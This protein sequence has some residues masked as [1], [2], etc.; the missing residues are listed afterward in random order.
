MLYSQSYDNTFD[1]AY[2]CQQAVNLYWRLS[3]KSGN[4]L[5]YDRIIEWLHSELD[6]Y[7]ALIR[8]MRICSARATAFCSTPS[9]RWLPPSSARIRAPLRLWGSRR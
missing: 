5:P 4:T 9:T 3:D 1:Q 7:D 8:T 2:A 6:R